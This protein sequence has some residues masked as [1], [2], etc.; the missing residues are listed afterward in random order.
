MKCDFV[1]V[2]KWLVDLDVKLKCIYEDN[3][4]GKLFDYIFVMFIVDYDMEWEILK[5]KVVELEKVLEKVWD[6]KVDIDC[7]VV[8]I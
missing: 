1:L 6:V 7:F 2:K 3:M 4:S 8:F 5:V